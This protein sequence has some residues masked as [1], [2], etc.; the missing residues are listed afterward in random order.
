M[1]I[2]NTKDGDDAGDEFHKQK[3][4]TIRNQKPDEDNHD[5]INV[6]SQPRIEKHA[7]EDGTN[8]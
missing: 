4:E 7:D 2:N 8:T 1:Q 3:L 6:Q 5:E